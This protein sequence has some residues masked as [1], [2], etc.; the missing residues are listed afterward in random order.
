MS[1]LISS[2]LI[3]PIIRQAR[4][5][6]R[7]TT[8]S[9]PAPILSDD[10]EATCLSP[11][12]GF[13]CSSK[14]H[15]HGNRSMT[16]FQHD[17]DW[18]LDGGQ[19]ERSDS[20]RS[21]STP[22]DSRD[23]EPHGLGSG[24]TIDDRT[25]TSQ[26]HGSE[27]LHANNNE[28]PQ[29]PGTSRTADTSRTDFPQE[30]RTAMSNESINFQSYSFEENG[31]QL[32]EDDGMGVLRRKIHAIRDK[33]APTAEKARLIHSLMTESYNSS[34]NNFNHNSSSIAR[35]PS[36]VRSLERPLTSTSPKTR[37]SFDQLSLAPVSSTDSIYN[38]TPQDLEPTFVPK[39]DPDASSNNN[40]AAVAECLDD[41]DYA[42]EEEEVLGC[43]HYK[44]NV[45]LQCY[46]CKRWYTCRFCH[47]E[48]EDHSLERRKTENML[49][50]LCGLPQP[51][52]QWCKGCG[53]RAASYFCAVCKLWDNDSAKSIYHCYDCGICR[54]G[55][56]LGKDFFHCKTCSVCM[57][58]SIENAHRCIERST[59]C[60]CP[61]CGEYMFTSPDT[62]VFM[63]CGHSIHHKCYAEYS[64]TSYRCPICSKSITNMEARFRNLDRTIESQPMPAE[65]RDTKALIYCNDCS[66]KSA[67]P[68]HW[69]GLKC[70]LCESYN[71]IQ[72]RLLRG[73]EVE[74]AGNDHSS[75]AGPQP[76]SSSYG[77][78]EIRCGP[79]TSSEITGFVPRADLYLR[80]TMSTS[81]DQDYRSFQSRSRAIS[82]A[83]S[84]YF[85]LS[86]DSAASLSIFSR[87][88]SDGD[89]TET[90]GFWGSTTL[91][92]R[93][94]FF[95]GDSES[96]DSESETDD[97]GDEESTEDL[98]E[99]DEDDVDPIE[100]FGH[101]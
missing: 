65:F 44:R 101:R 53:E 10:R 5:L 19:R 72:I 52:A 99:D 38:L 7:Q 56:G 79:E 71:T 50:M 97:D 76:R 30:T 17:S 95:R 66:A 3:G 42:E 46:T 80:S 8:T 21:V 37:R 54:I 59:Q 58:I 84:N 77:I 87:R 1:G 36:S 68:Y 81:L 23:Q 94:P 6:S 28:I 16:D 85:G 41:A 69:L 70:D 9:E 15:D 67:V 89:E 48:V 91:R 82:P 24:S 26:V 47:D 60:D 90:L 100:I 61:I 25:Q 39:S 62:V 40:Q 33:D 34:Q 92:Y 27:S 12:D 22:L 75:D 86:R 31:Q 49:C 20:L 43:R 11:P 29:E 64:K 57:P 45:K 93:Y 2:L 73:T 32:P 63:R 55:K 51:A 83:V 35:S 98:D 78:N 74:V 18:G 14:Q 88:R 4:R 13:P 96:T